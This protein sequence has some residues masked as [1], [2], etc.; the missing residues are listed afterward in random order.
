MEDS[1]NQAE[2][3]NKQKVNDSGTS[4]NKHGNER[5]KSSSYTAEQRRIAEQNRIEL[6]VVHTS[7]GNL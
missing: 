5:I 4:V 6:G 2:K 1:S 7:T 3:N